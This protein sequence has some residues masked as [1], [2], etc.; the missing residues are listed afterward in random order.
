MEHS[1]KKHQNFFPKMFKLFSVYIMLTLSVFFGY[2][3]IFG[4][5][6]PSEITIP[7]TDAES[8]SAFGKFVEKLAS[9]QNVDTDFNLVFENKD[10]SVAAQ[11]NVVVDMASKNVALDIDLI[12]NQQNFDIKATYVS[13]NLYLTVDENAYKFD[14]SFSFETGEVDFSKI[15]DF[16]TKNFDIDLSFLD[17][18]GEFLGID[19]KNFDPDTLMSKL[20]IEDKEDTE[21]GDVEFAISLGKAVGA[22][23]LCDKDFNIK[24]A[25]LKDILV[26][27]NTIKFSADVNKMNKEDVI[28]SYE[29]TGDEI[30]MSGLTLYTTYTQNLFKN[31]FVIGNVVVK[32]G[33]DNYNG[34]LYY[35]A[36]ENVKVRLETEYEGL[37]IS[38]TYANEN[39]YVE[40]SELKLCFAIKDFDKW[41]T[42]ISEIVEKQTSKELATWLEDLLKQYVNID[43]EN[44]NVQDIVMKVLG[45]CFA[46]SDKISD[47]LPSETTLDENQF[48]MTW[49]NGLVVRFENV[50]ETL[51]SVGVVYNDVDVKADFEIAQSGFDVAGEYFDLTNLLPLSNVVDK[52][53]T[54]KQMSA[55]MTLTYKNQTFDAV[56]TFDLA[57]KIVAGIKTELFGEKVKVVLNDNQIYIVVGEV[58]IGG[59]IANL[60]SYLTKVDEIFGTSL[61][62]Y[63]NNGNK[64]NIDISAIIGKIAGILKDLKLSSKDGKVA[65]ITY[66]SN[67]ANVT[68]TNG[69]VV[70]GFEGKGISATAKIY[71]SNKTIEIPEVSTDVID[72]VLAKVENLKKY[73]DAKEFAFDIVGTYKE[74]Q[75]EMSIKAD[76]NNNVYEISGFEIGGNVLN[77]RYEN[78]VV[79]VEYGQNKLKAEVEN[80]KQIAEIV[81]QIVKANSPA[82]TENVAEDTTEEQAIDL[83]KILTQIFGEDVSKLSLE[84]LMQ[85]LA[86][87]VNGSLDNLEIGVSYNGQKVLTA[88]VNV[89]FEDNNFVGAD[90]SLEDINLSVVRKTFALEEIGADEYYDL[91]AK[92]SGKFDLIY[93]SG[94]ESITVTADIKLDLSDKIYAYVSMV[95]MGESVELVVSNNLLY[96]KIG[97]IEVKTNFNSAKE[98]YEYIVEIFEIV[99]PGADIDWEEILNKLDLNGRNILQIAGLDLSISAEAVNVSYKANDNLKVALKLENVDVVEIKEIPE[100]AEDL[101]FLIGK[102]ASIKKM[103]SKGFVEFGFKANV[104][105]LDVD[106]TLKYANGNIEIC[107]MFVCGENVT[108]RI[109]NNFVYFAYGNMK[110]RFEIP[111][112]SGNENSASMKEILQKITSDNLGVV[113][114]FGVYEEILTMLRDYTLEDY[115]TKLLLDI[116]GSLDE[117]KVSISNKREYS[118]SEI[119]NATINFEG[120]NL[121]SARIK[122]YSSIWAEITINDVEKST[123]TPFNE[124]DY[125]DYATDFVEGVFNSLEVEK[126][127]YAF[128]SDISIRYSNNT[129]YGKLTAMLVEDESKEG[130]LG[131]YIP[132]VSVTTSSLGLNSYIYLLGNDVYIDINGLQITADLTKTTIE[133]IMNFVEENFG[134]SLSSD[135]KAA[136]KAVEV[137]KV[138]LPAIDK[139]KGAWISD[140]EISSNGVQVNVDSSLWYSENARFYDMVLQ[141]FIQNYNNTIVPTKIVLGANIDDPNTTTY[142]D[143]SE[144][145]LKNGDAVIETDVTNRLNFAVYLTDVTVGKYVKGLDEIFVGKDYKNISALKSNYGTTNLTDYNSYKVVLDAVK[146]VYDYGMSMQYQAR[147]DVS[148]AGE[149]STKVGGNI[150]VAVTDD[151][152]QKAQFKL[153]DN[154]ILRVHGDLDIY[155]NFGAQ[156]Q[157]LHQLSILYDNYDAGLFATYSHGDHIGKNNFKAKISNAHMSDIVSMIVKF[158]DL[159]LSEEMNSALNLSECPTDFRYLRSL[160]GMTKHVSDGEVSEVDKVLS[161]VTEM[162][163]ILKEIKLEKTTIEDSELFETKLSAK[164]LWE[165]EIASV[166]IILRE[167]K[168]EDGTVK[169]VLRE[170][171]VENFNF[172][173]SA[174]NAKITLQDYNANNFDYDTSAKHIDF[175]EVSSFM[176]VAVNTL[177]TKGFSFTGSADVAIGSWDAITVNYDLFASL[178]VEGKVYLYFE[179]DVPSF[180]DVT[181]DL[182]GFGSTYT[183][184]SAGVGFDNRISVLEYKDGVLNVTQTTYGYKKN[185]FVSKE[186]KV[187]SWSHNADQIGNDIM[188]IMAEALG[189]TDTV[190][191]AIKGLVASMNPNPSL[192]ETI[193]GFAKVSD[194]YTLRLDGETLTGSSSFRD[195][196]VKLGLSNI[197]YDY[198]GKAYQ[199]IDSVTTNINISDFVKIPVNLKSTN[200]GTSYTTGYG[201][202]IYT[203]DYYRKMSIDASRYLKVYFANCYNAEFNSSMLVTGDKIV[204]PNLTTREDTKGDVTTY[205]QFDGWYRDSTFKNAVDSDVY[206]GSE[207]LV[208]YAKWKVTKVVK[209]CA[210]NVYDG[211]TL[212][213]T[214]RIESGDTIDLSEIPGVNEDTKFYYDALFTREVND[215]VMPENDL[216]IYIRNKY[217]VTV[218]S[219]YGNAGFVYSGYQGEALVLPTQTSYVE[220]DGNVRTTYTF[221]GWSEEIS[222]V[223]NRDVTITANWVAETKHYYTISFDLRWYIVFDTVDGSAWK[224]APPAIA[225]EKLLEGTVID[226]NQDKYKVVGRAYTSAVRPKKYIDWSTK[227]YF[228]ATSWGTSAWADY[229]KKGSGFTSYTVIGN[230]TLYACW[231]KQ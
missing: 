80:A 12:Y 182:G 69:N 74:T 177:N 189:L 197:Y 6:K 124:E 228:K 219:D 64:D 117:I 45:E 49:S 125:K 160:L 89:K 192:E 83:S 41:N 171:S 199:F 1:T 99:I 88:N 81:M 114:D 57:D 133:E 55:D 9:F 128:A 97:E 149:T 112:N 174:I 48:V 94:E 18:V 198:D 180:A 159:K 162:T 79:F 13:P 202:E 3:Q 66:L 165:G 51:S 170:I 115:N 167:E 204:F 44:A 32:V 19:F 194:G 226:L 70:I 188:Q 134:V 53:L 26:K 76:L 21:T 222:S 122:L 85:K 106:G 39:V 129:F 102:A 75:I 59:D 107:D 172:G 4:D 113:I 7:D 147:V 110:L 5:V 109:Q 121:K 152:E 93:T 209:T 187:K 206:M 179:L 212:I 67:V 123:M 181:Y 86:V 183:Y 14:T 34:K 36:S 31:N 131:H 148:M 118:N 91:T 120:D 169:L 132:M 141:A 218:V 130:M 173:G 157:V 30:D 71:A 186:R 43:F 111:E 105:G 104:W 35:D 58:V 185:A 217:T 92:H 2:V 203:N 78:G 231:E 50:N 73:V 158:A 38:L 37:P 166:A 216:N 195:F 168:A 10:M 139:I 29:E 156:N 201:K 95:V 225:S 61:A 140:V 47:Y 229:T 164:I 65:V 190:Y 46:N 63:I 211:E 98:L 205:Y 176:N 175:S 20:K 96:A 27:G 62:G 155:T 8:D 142:D 193:L 11:G 145:L 17:D 40:V 143:Y 220:D 119:L 56:A 22:K 68:V 208:F 223:P 82:G 52:I 60:N 16:V 84:E 150:V 153:F 146:A 42:T 154:K 101:K 23:I 137:F 178:D 191:D 136:E 184:Y 126:D 224:D 25:K 100:N 200:S 72:D 135:V 28:V 144:Y 227:E 103:I 33:D 77:V 161:S 24:S 54:S 163:K 138:I 196:D 230:Q 207:E 215:F 108:I 210:L 221:M 213:K 127:V 116:A 214:I 15:I 87:V 90:A 151:V